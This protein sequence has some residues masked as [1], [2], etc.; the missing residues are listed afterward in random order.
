MGQV[1]YKGKPRSPNIFVSVISV[2]FL[3]FYLE[4]NNSPVIL[5]RALC[6]RDAARRVPCL[7]GLLIYK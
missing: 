3:D 5:G 6:R 1:G 7:S 2:L 4:S